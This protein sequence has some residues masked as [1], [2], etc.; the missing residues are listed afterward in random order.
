MEENKSARQVV[1]YTFYKLDA[2]AFLRL[3]EEKQR[4]AK[5]DLIDTVRTFNRRMLLRSYTLVG[6][7]S[8]VDFL[9]WTVAEDVE[10]VQELETAI[11]NTALGPFLDVPRSFLSG[12]KR[13]IYDIS[14]PED[15]EKVDAEARIRIEPS[16]SKYLFVYPFIKTRAWYAL[17]REERQEMMTEHIRVGR[18]Y[19]NVRLNTTYSYG[20]DDQEFVV[21]FEGDDPHE[22]VDLVAD[23]RLTQASL[24]TLRDT[25]MHICLAMPLGEVMD[26]IGGAHVSD[27]VDEDVTEVGGWLPV[28]QEDELAPESSRLVYYGTQQVALFRANG[29]LYALN[30]RCPHARGPLCEGTLSE[31]GHGPAV[32]CPWH[33]AHFSL[34][35]GEVIDGPSPRAVETFRVKVEDGTVFIA[36]GEAE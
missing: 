24:Y 36:R 29:G 21:A 32:R 28:A 30:N 11:R 7:R 10:P 14:L 35:T 4:A 15:S 1:K 9:L 26:S 16:G 33:E 12:T 17:S 6:M 13:S 25:P 2:L 18:Q 22:F 20:I 5:L 27:L 19:P 23:L 31:N 34:E 8:D 3:P